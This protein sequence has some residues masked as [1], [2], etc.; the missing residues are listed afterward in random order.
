[1]FASSTVVPGLKGKSHLAKKSRHLKE[2]EVT[3]NLLQ[4]EDPASKEERETCKINLILP[5]IYNFNIQYFIDIAHAY[6]NKVREELLAEGEEGE[7]IFEKFIKA[8][9]DAD[10]VLDTEAGIKELY[11]KVVEL[12]Q[13]RNDLLEP[14]VSF[15]QSGEALTC[16]KAMEN[17]ELA[18]MTDFLMKAEVKNKYLKLKQAF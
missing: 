11:T 13:G 2:L 8:L 15:L 9:V 10:E 17:I 18:N 3:L 7:L 1:M 6:L 14:F 4:P 16:G 5:R 12:F